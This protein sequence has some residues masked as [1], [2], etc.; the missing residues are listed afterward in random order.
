MNQNV[1]SVMLRWGRYLISIFDFRSFQSSG[2]ST[3]SARLRKAWNASGGPPAWPCLSRFIMK[4]A[5]GFLII[6]I[7]RSGLQGDS[8]ESVALTLVDV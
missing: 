8:E 6:I 2:L 4:L 3:C 5:E 1:Q 7:H